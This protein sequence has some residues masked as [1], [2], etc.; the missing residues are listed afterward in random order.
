MEYQLKEY[1]KEYEN[2]LIDLLIEVCV[3]EYGLGHYKD[4][5]IE[6]VKSNEAKKRWILLHEDSL[7]ATVCYTERSKEI[8]EIKKVYVKKEYRNLGIGKKMVNMVIDYI[9]DTQ[10]YD[11]IYVGTSDHF[12]SARKFYEKLGFKFK[13][14]EGDGYLLEMKLAGNA[15][16]CIA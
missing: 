2:E 5:L 16:E 13:D 6:H 14:Y 1:S 9:K 10:K 8:S 7:I 3:E 11:A 12:E 15:K 4:G